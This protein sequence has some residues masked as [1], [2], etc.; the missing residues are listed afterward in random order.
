ML[1]DERKKEGHFKTFLSERMKAFIKTKVKDEQWSPEQ[2]SE[3]AK[4]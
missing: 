1:A 3:D 2:I 4:H